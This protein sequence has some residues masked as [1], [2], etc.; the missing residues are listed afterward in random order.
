L[1]EFEIKDIR[2]FEVGLYKYFESA[3]T[4]LIED[5]TKKKALDDDLRGKLHAALKE[6]AANFKAELTAAKA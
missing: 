5:L 4:P 2:A 3:Q 6:Y 1:D